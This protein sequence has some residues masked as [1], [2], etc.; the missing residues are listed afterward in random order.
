MVAA[1]GQRGRREGGADSPGAC[2]R[3][4]AASRWPRRRPRPSPRHR[5]T[6]W[7]TARPPALAR[8]ESGRSAW[9]EHAH[10]RGARGLTAHHER[11]GEHEERDRD[12][13]KALHLRHHL[14]H[15]AGQAARGRRWRLR[16]WPRPAAHG[17]WAWPC[18]A[19][20]MKDEKNEGAHGEILGVGGGAYQCA[21]RARPVSAL[22]ALGTVGGSGPAAFQVDLQCQQRQH[23]H[24]H[25]SRS[26]RSATRAPA[27]WATSRRA[28]SPASGTWPRA[29][30]PYSAATTSQDCQWT[31]MRR[32]RGGAQ[33]PSESWW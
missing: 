21:T 10:Q 23:H 2:A 32:S 1:A 15:Q 33:R 26:R 18:T 19:A 14:L 22:G 13:R 6:V 25:P 7:T 4:S 31:P 5:R 30:V 3:G 17:R 11:A 8:H 28:R 24:A 9:T 29:S 27:R 20:P 12:Q 16:P